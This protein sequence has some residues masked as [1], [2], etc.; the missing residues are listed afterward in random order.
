MRHIKSSCLDLHSNRGATNSL[1]TWV[2]YV[3][4]SLDE[5]LKSL[6]TPVDDKRIAKAVRMNDHEN[7]I[8]EEDDKDYDRGDIFLSIHCQA[9]I[10]IS[11]KALLADFLSAWLKRWCISPLDPATT[12]RF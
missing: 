7:V 4:L 1:K 12:V 2:D 3:F 9:K 6:H 8:L 5:L 11:Q 10:L